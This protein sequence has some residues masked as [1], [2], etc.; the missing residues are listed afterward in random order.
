M[1]TVSRTVSYLSWVFL[2]IVLATSCRSDRAIQGFE[3]A[4]SK[5]RGTIQNGVLETLSVQ[6]TFSDTVANTGNSPLLLLGEYDNV[7]TQV[8]LKFNNIPDSVTILNAAVVLLANDLV[9]DGTS[10]STFQ[11]FVHE[12]TRAWEENKVTYDNFN[13]GFDAQVLATADIEPITEVV[14]GIDSTVAEPVRFEFNAQ[15]VDLVRQWADTTRANNFGV[16][17]DAPNSSFIKEFL[18]RGNLSGQPRLELTT[19]KEGEIDTVSITV[20][21]DAF[22]VRKLFE[23]PAGPL[24]VDNL[25]TT[26]TVLEFDLS[27]LPRETTINDA[28]LV[29]NVDQENSILQGDITTL[30]LIRLNKAFEPPQ[31]FVIDSSFV[32]IPISLTRASKE[33][34]VPIRSLMQA[35]VLEIFE[36]HGFIIQTASPGRDVNRVAF[37]SSATDA[38]RAPRITVDYTTAPAN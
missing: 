1:N 35:W 27:G 38:A 8:L 5:E 3:L 21:E 9:S 25:F 29:L 14:V 26:A 7:A 28:S 18:S 4:D 37:Y 22:I 34:K 12:V 6:A 36:N 33:I 16:L 11:A 19:Q 20:A 2:S 10:K 32:A 23:P 31:S 15:G 30:R 24:Y 13:Q 17:I